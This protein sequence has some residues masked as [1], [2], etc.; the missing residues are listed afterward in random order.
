[1]HPALLEIAAFR[2]ED[3]FDG[4][5]LGADQVKALLSA[6]RDALLSALET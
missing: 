6:G 5:G 1:M 3:R 4:K 2:A